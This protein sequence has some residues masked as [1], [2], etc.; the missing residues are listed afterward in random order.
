MWT[1]DQGNRRGQLVF[2]NGQLSFMTV[3]CNGRVI[4]ANVRDL[5]HRLEFHVMIERDAELGLRR[6]LVDEVVAGYEVGSWLDGLAPLE[7]EPLQP[8][9]RS[10]MLKQM[11]HMASMRRHPFPSWAKREWKEALALVKGLSE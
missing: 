8:E 3:T 1:L 4:A 9:D 7:D 11:N 6:V 2:N 5:A 10:F